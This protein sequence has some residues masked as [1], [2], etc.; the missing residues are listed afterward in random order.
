M[1]DLY[2]HWGDN[3]IISASHQ[4]ILEHDRI[5]IKALDEKENILVTGIDSAESAINFAK[6]S[7]ILDEGLA[8]SSLSNS[9]AEALSDVDLIISTGCVGY[10][11]EKSFENFCRP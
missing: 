4:N 8:V 6:D 2:E 10:I 5:F 7:G 11:T 1:H 3:S 9:R